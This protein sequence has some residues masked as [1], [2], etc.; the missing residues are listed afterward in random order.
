MFGEAN[1]YA[2]VWHMDGTR[3]A[4]VVPLEP[5]ET[6]LRWQIV[7]VCD[8]NGD[9]QPDLLWQHRDTGQNCAWIMNGAQRHTIEVPDVTQREPAW[10]IAGV[11]DLDGDGAPDWVWHNRDTGIVEVWLMDGG[12]S[13]RESRQLGCET[14]ASWTLSGI[15]GIGRGGR[16]GAL[17]RRADGGALRIWTLV[18]ELTVS[19]LPAEPDESW[20][21]AGMYELD[22]HGAWGLVWRHA[23]S[24]A[25][26]VWILKDSGLEEQT[27]LEAVP[28]L[29]WQIAGIVGSGVTHD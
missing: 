8:L 22:G 21:V 4:A 18:P 27:A 1:G 7:A 26:R 28:E 15:G 10:R 6:D 29:R 5:I 16:P 3:T 19:V 12:L 23:G 14:D 25:N 11:A 24:G 2:A 20:L 9:G 17:W 13:P